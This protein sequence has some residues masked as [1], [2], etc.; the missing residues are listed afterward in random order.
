MV[1]S[2]NSLVFVMRSSCVFH[3]TGIDQISSIVQSVKY[4]HDVNVDYI[5]VINFPCTLIRLAPYVPAERS[6]N[7]KKCG[8]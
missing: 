5:K 3:E 4:I 2:L 8:L 7:L 1:I 6:T